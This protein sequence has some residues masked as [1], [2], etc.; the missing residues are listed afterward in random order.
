MKDKPAPGSHRLT[1][2][3]MVSRMERDAKGNARE[4][5]LGD[6]MQIVVFPPDT[7]DAEVSNQSYEAFRTAA[8]KA[9]ALIPNPK[10]ATDTV[11]AP[12]QIEPTAS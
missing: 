6:G 10:P 12:K 11:E 9:L 8:V 4:V 1:V 2:H 7:P 5:Y 3:L